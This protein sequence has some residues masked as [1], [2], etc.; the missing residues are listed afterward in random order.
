MI[1][2]NSA[3]P[4]GE[5]KLRAKRRRFIRYVALTCLVFAV[6]GL[7]VGFASAAAEDATVPPYFLL[8]LI[9]ASLIGFV[10]FSRN[11]FTRVD[12]VDLLDNLWA[13]LIGMYFYIVAFPLWE[14]LGRVGYTS[15][16]DHWLIWGATLTVSMAVYLYRKFV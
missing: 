15:P 16:P 4:S 7:I 3:E 6:A 12:E 9:A 13:S 1:N 11:Y 14:L 2:T 10:V 8:P 5:E